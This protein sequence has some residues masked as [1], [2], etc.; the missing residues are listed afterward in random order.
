[1]FATGNYAT[2]WE[3]EDKG[4]YSEVALSTSRKNKET[5][6]Y[7]TDFSSK[8]V[9]FIGT[10]HEMAS[11][12]KKQDRI[13]LGNC[14]V[15]NSYNKETKKGYTNF[16]VFSFETTDNDTSK[17]AKDNAKKEKATKAK[18]KAKVEE[19]VDDDEDEDL[20]F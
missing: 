3:V 14:G 10:A 12:L 20:P 6:Q 13:K 4:N 18:S 9:R 5:N 11:E 8:F 16:C 15:T 19:V 2:V 7:E 17:N 1:M